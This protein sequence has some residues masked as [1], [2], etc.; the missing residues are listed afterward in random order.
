MPAVRRTV[1]ATAVLVPGILA[2]SACAATVTLTPAA[3]RPGGTV[4]ITGSGFAPRAQTTVQVGKTTRRAATGS[5]GRVSA[6][7]AVAAATAPGARRVVVRV[8]RRRVA[9]TA[10]VSRQ[11]QPAT[12]LA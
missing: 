5:E 10:T 7:L 3:L 1:L 6:V 8:G 4:H 2:D 9:T 12:A 11:A